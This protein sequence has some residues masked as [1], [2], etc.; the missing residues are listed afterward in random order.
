MHDKKMTVI[1]LSA[2]DSD[3]MTLELSVLTSLL[4]GYV[5]EFTI[6]FHSFISTI[7]NNSLLL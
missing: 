2:V 6:N 1:G 5:A 3:L 7:N 4:L